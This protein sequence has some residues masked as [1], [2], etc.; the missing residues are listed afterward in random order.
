[1]FDQYRLSVTDAMENNSVKMIGSIA[2]SLVSKTLSS[3]ELNSN[4]HKKYPFVFVR[5]YLLTGTS[6]LPRRD[7]WEVYARIIMQYNLNDI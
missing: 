3:I 1:M 5:H 7:K 6:T 4:R 2:A